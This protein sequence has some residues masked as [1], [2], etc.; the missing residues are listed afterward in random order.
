MKVKDVMRREVTTVAPA[1]PLKEVATILS[2]HGFSGLP[3]VADGGRVVGVV[4]EADILAKERGPTERRG[5]LLGWLLEPPD[6]WAEAKLDARTA[7]EAMSAP[8][9]TVEPGAAVA[10]AAGIMVERGIN[11]L[12]VVENGELVG[13]VTRADLVRAFTRND[14]EIEREIRE[15]VVAQQLWIDPSTLVI[16]AKDGLVTLRGQVEKRSVADVL[17]SF[18]QRVPGVVAVTN[19][20]TWQEDD[21]A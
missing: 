9:I 10:A 13:I 20:L 6:V 11:R 14:V 19:E 4:S 1:T 18:A 17:A 12:P 3:V 2:E 21:R 8:A 15:D 5:G 7:E 16:R